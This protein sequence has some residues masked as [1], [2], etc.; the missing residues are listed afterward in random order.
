[1]R[2]KLRENI[3]SITPL[4]KYLHSSQIWF[5]YNSRAL[6]WE[7]CFGKSIPNE[8]GTR[9]KVGWNKRTIRLACTE[10]IY[11]DVLY[12]TPFNPPSQPPVP[13]DRPSSSRLP[14]SRPARRWNLFAAEIIYI[15]FIVRRSSRCPRELPR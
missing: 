13:L 9:I 1:M 2:N 7:K 15:L 10:C 14:P 6:M 3:L 5:Q 8:E 4:T 12:R 11:N